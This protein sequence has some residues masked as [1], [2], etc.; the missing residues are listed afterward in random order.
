LDKKL[1]FYRIKKMKF[2]RI[3]KIFV[4]KIE[5]LD[6]KNVRQKNKSKNLVRNRNFGLKSDFEQYY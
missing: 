5:I 2:Y 6:K 3:N 4:T 1:K